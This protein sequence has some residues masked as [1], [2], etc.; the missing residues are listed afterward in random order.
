MEL[1]QEPGATGPAL[2]TAGADADT[3]AGEATTADAGGDAAGTDLPFESGP[4]PRKRWPLWSKIVVTLSV[5]VSV[6]II[7]GFVIRVPYATIAPGEAV[8]LA[9]RVTVGGAR[10]YTTPR[11]DIRLL[12]VRERNHV[13]LWRYLQA[14]LDPDIDLYRE[15]EINP[16]NKSQADL[17]REALQAMDQAKSSATAVALEKAGYPVSTEVRDLVKG[18]PA[19][20]ILRAG[21]VILSADGHAIT[22]PADLSKVVQRHAKGEEVKLV[23]DRGGKHLRLAV[24]VGEQDGRKLIGV[25]VGP[26]TQNGVKVDIDTSGIGG[27]SAGLAMA[28]A[29]YDDLT[30]GDLTGGKRVAVTGTI[31]LD[32]NVGEIGGINQK[33]VA[34]RTAGAQLFIVP[35]CSPQD[36]P[37]AK[38]ACEN[39]LSRAVKRAGSGIKVVPVSTFDQALQALRNAGGDPVPAAA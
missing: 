17:N 33:A 27:P 15:K 5:I 31:D 11:G 10:A 21:D 13:S 36:P 24:P 6:A 2:W 28:L 14:K 23:I 38:T 19:Y 26:K 8:P 22:H 4:P 35:R 12:F 39:D 18:L 34:A 9:N 7:A 20:G 25:L 16:S 29:I 32:G 1:N 37:E 3:A 30:P